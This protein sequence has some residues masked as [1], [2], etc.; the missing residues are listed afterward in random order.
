MRVSF[1]VPT[2]N[3]TTLVENCLVSLRQFHPDNEV[4]VVDDGSTK[5]IQQRLKPI[6]EKYNSTLLTSFWNN[7]FGYTV[8]RGICKSSGDVAVLVNNDITFTCKITDEIIDKMSK[9]Q[10]IGI[11]GCLLYLPNGN[12]QHGGHKRMGRTSNFTHHDHYNNPNKARAS[13]NNWYNI[14]VTGALMAIRKSMTD[15]IGVFKSGYKLA[16]EDV[17]FCLRA[18]HCGWRIWYSSKISAIHHEGATRGVS[19]EQKQKAGMLD[20]ELKSQEQ[21]NKDVVTFNIDQIQNRIKELNSGIEGTYDGTIGVIRTGALG[22]CIIATGIIKHLKERNPLSDIVVYSQYPNIFINHGYI[23][24]IYSDKLAMIDNCDKVYNLDLAYESRPDVNRIQAYGDAVFGEGNYDMADIKPFMNSE[25]TKGISSVIDYIVISPSKSWA[26]RELTQDVWDSIIKELTKYFV[27]VMVG[28]SKDIQP[29]PCKNFYNLSDKYN[30]D[31]VRKIISEAKCFIGVDSGLLHL[32]QT[33][34][35]KAVGIFSCSDPK[36]IVWREENT[37]AIEPKT[38][39]K[40]CLNYKVKPPVDYLECEKGTNECIKSI[41][42]KDIID[43]V[44]E[45]C[46]VAV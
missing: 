20:A 24:S 4:V 29:T 31:E 35:V 42:A 6:C 15:E 9:D 2:Y 46:N 34:N 28:T 44:K 23:K 1:V 21:Y 11:M 27:V 32:A 36:L 45:V 17:E 8:N 10:R 16:F 13:Y 37:F 22:D 19:T 40:Y 41:K 43:K 5:D 39:C 7:G 33:T 25:E 14:G 30:L 18:W 12:I 38:K 3:A 26:C